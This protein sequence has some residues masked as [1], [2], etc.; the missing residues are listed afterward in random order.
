[1]ST[2]VAGLADPARYAAGV[3]HDEFARLREHTPVAWVPE[4]PLLRRDGS[5]VSTR[6]GTGFWAVTRH[7]TV[8]AVARDPATF[9]SE[10]RGAFL[11]DP[12]TPEDLQ[13]AR[14]LLANMDGAR[15]ATARRL[16]TPAFSPAA[17]DALRGAVHRH[18]T[19]VLGRVLAAGEFDAV[20]DLAAELPL[21]VLADLLGMPPGDRGLL[22]RW[23][24]NL[25][26]F[27]DP[28]YG[29]G[30]VGV[31]RD[32][33]AEAGRYVSELAAYRRRSPG[34]DLVSRLLR[35]D[36][37][38]EVLSDPQLLAFWMLLVVAGNETTRHLISGALLALT[39]WPAQRDRL[40]ADPSLIPT[41]AEELL[42]WVT[43]IMQFRRTALRDTVLDGQPIAAG[44]KVVVSYTSANRD[45]RVF[46]EPQCL[47][48]GRT[49][50]PHLAFGT[51]PHTCLGARLTHLEFQT[52]L[53]MLLPHLGRLS[54]TGPVIRLESNFM[55][56]IK[57]MPARF[58]P[59]GRRLR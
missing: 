20:A 50:N 22:L 54:L 44:D 45:E 56:G 31:Y 27:D 36:G 28:E 51:G 43:P 35:T 57:S 10:E 48:L 55:N 58:A 26:G 25:V 46:A 19:A 13:R 1:V 33:F 34:D 3:P 7:A 16:V 32:T 49:P 8:S 5:G 12:A 38:D 9:S 17:L 59:A 21:L 39:E 42:R 23:S 24:N 52:L 40:I 4:P 11:A 29:G 37:S 6:A 18:A 47:D 30:D 15:H 2:G 14:Q 53:R 41:A